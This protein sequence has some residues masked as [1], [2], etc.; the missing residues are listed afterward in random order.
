MSC[1]PPKVGCNSSS[2]IIICPD[3]EQNSYSVHA[4]AFIVDS[5][6]IYSS[7][8][9]RVF[10][11]KTNILAGC[12]PSTY[13]CNFMLNSSRCQSWTGSACVRLID[14]TVFTELE[15]C[16]EFHVAKIAYS[17][18]FASWPS[19]HSNN[20]FKHPG[21]LSS[22]FTSFWKKTNGLRISHLQNR[23]GKGSFCAQWDAT[24]CTF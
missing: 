19:V 22:V 9:C 20:I 24:W 11:S 8:S 18:S 1:A 10:T 6:V 3:F 5:I 23:E 4:R 16:A 2:T 17:W 15:M 14:L 12:T 13:T 7:F 21:F